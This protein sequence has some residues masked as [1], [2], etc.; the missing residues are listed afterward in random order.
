M[1]YGTLGLAVL[2]L[3]LMAAP[4]T[5]RAQGAQGGQDRRPGDIPGP[6]DS[7]QD[8]QDTGRMLFALADENGDGQISQKEATDA[9]NLLVGG[10]FFSAD[11]NGD[12]KVTQ[13][14]G[15]QAREAF[16]SQRP[17][18]RYVLDTARATRAQQGNQ[19]GGNNPANTNRQNPFQGLAN[20]LDTNNDK[21]L[22]ATE[23]RQ[24]V[25]T[26]VQGIFASA[27]T[28]RDNQLSRTE[29][30][31][32]MAG[33]ARQVAQA[34]FQ[35]ADTDGNGQISQAEFEKSLVQ[36]G[37]VVFNVLDANKDGQ[38]SPQEAQQARRVIMSKLRPLMAPEAPNSPRHAV[39]NAV[40][41]AQQGGQPGAPSAPTQP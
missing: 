33:V 6:I 30:N 40:N 32:A 17:W 31:A 3:G 16:L 27:D 37:R 18:L 41:Q 4:A 28:N 34:A 2:A 5:V 14:E 19:P 1:K 35:Q 36:P 11:A 21:Q 8:L 7:V 9:G 39:Q 23:V 22:E 12:G 13:D 24:A 29:V 25:Q 20:V 15:R 26:A 10:F 38:I